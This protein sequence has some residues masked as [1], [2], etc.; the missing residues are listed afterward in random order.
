MERHDCSDSG[1]YDPAD[2]L[3]GSWAQRMHASRPA[4][5]GRANRAACPVAAGL[6]SIYRPST[7]REQDHN[8]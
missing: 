7:I 8:M 6:K 3:A 5:A 1:T 2:Y 4:R